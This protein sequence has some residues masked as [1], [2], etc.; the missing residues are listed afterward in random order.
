MARHT[1][2]TFSGDVT[3]TQISPDGELLAY[4]ERSRLFVQDLT[5]GT[6]I[7]I[8]PIGSSVSS[9]RWSPDGAALLFS[10]ADTTQRRV[11]VTYPR[12]GGTPRP[13]PRISPFVVWSPDGVQVAQWW[14]AVPNDIN[15]IRFTTLGTG[16]T[17]FVSI[18]D[19]LGFFHGDWSPNGR[20]IALKAVI[21]S[22]G[23][24]ALWTVA[25]DGSGWHRLVQDSGMSAPIWSPSGDAVYY[26][27]GDELL[28]VRVGSDGASHK[29]KRRYFLA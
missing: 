20:F 2:L 24:E 18:P 12:L 25:V 3:W 28:K 1:Q 7:E 8:T 19:S 10:G 14:Q 6:V 21:P 22:T 15:P 4:V 29:C 17:S 23:S 9:L 16:D 13:L 11:T 5:G 27:R 26:V